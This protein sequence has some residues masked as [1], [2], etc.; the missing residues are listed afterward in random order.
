MSAGD[1]ARLPEVARPGGWSELSY[2]RLHGSPR[3]YYS[4]YTTEFINTI[5][6]RMKDALRAGGN[7]W[8]I[9]DNTASGAATGNALALKNLLSLDVE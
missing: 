7:A 1:P 9:F 4:K 3:I 5:A 2:F 8:C 6:S